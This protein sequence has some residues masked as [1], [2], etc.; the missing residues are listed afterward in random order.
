MGFVQWF[1]VSMWGFV[2]H[3]NE[4]WMPQMRAH[5]I[6][7]SVVPAR[8]DACS[9]SKQECVCTASSMDV[10]P[11]MHCHKVFPNVYSLWGFQGNFVYFHEDLTR[12]NIVF[13]IRKLNS[14]IKSFNTFWYFN[15]TL[16]LCYILESLSLSQ[17]PCAPSSSGA[18]SSQCSPG[19][20]L[21][22]SHWTE[23]AHL[24]P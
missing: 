9:D 8:A 12:S 16:G 13:T 5:S 19:V 3:R 21:I 11:C 17:G 18:G 15:V 2:G 20:G 6:C 1:T 24:S 4:A 10:C 22:F 7:E 23:A 14:L